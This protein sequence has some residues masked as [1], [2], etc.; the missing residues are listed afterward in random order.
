VLLA[1]LGAGLAAGLAACGYGPVDV[2]DSTPLPGTQDA[3]AALL[4]T[5]PDTVA[6]AVRREVAPATAGV[7]A[8]GQPPVILRCGVPA[9]T[10]AD[11]TTALLDVDGVEWLPVPGQGG[12]FFTTVGR[13]VDVEVAVPDDYA[14]EADVLADLGRA[15]R[16]AVPPEPAG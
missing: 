15:V 13:A 16:E 5:L 7:A 11:P 4:A 9:P 10:G 14:P 6:D 3:C 8:W 1:G 2:P 12:T